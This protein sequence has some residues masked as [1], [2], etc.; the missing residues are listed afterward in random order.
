MKFTMARRC[1]FCSGFR[2]VVKVPDTVKVCTKH[3][4]TPAK[5]RRIRA[6]LMKVIDQPMFTEFK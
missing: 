4:F 3:D 2:G 1:P 6:R 5:K